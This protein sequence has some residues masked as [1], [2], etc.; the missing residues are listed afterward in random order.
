M[1]PFCL[2]LIQFSIQ[3]VSNRGH[4]HIDRLVVEIKGDPMLKLGSE[5]SC[6]PT[7]VTQAHDA[8][9][10][11]WNRARLGSVSFLFVFSQKLYDFRFQVYISLKTMQLPVSGFLQRP[12]C[13][14]YTKLKAFG[15]A[16]TIKLPKT[17]ANKEPA[18]LRRTCKHTCSKGLQYPFWVEDHLQL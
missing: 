11:Q 4:V 1:P 13:F 18:S 8:F 14:F 2:F 6:W 7:L 12:K 9:L 16:S 10:V 3:S 5:N 15:K 17:F